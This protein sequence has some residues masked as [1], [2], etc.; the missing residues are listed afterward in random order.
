[1]IATMATDRGIGLK[2]KTPWQQ[3]GIFLTT[4]MQHFRQMVMRTQTEKHILIKTKKKHSTNAIIMGRVTH[5]TTPHGPI[6]NCAQYVL[7]SSPQPSLNPNLFFMNSIDACIEHACN[8]WIRSSPQQRANARQDE[9]P[10]PSV[11]DV[12]IVGG[13]CVYRQFLTQRKY[14]L[15]DIWITRVQNN[16]DSDRFMPPFEHMFRRV[17]LS[18]VP[19]VDPY[20]YQFERWIPRCAHTDST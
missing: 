10:V 11:R 17:L 15:Y 6:Q 18:Y 3:E 9:V 7:T 20:L 5:N 16:F 1:M 13:E 12:W 4:N 2:K 14:P 19:Q 8:P